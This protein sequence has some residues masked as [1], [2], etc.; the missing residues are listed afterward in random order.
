MQGEYDEIDR[1]DVAWLVTGGGLRRAREDR[2]AESERMYTDATAC[3]RL[4][5]EDRVRIA[6]QDYE[7]MMEVAA[8]DRRRAKVAL[9]ARKGG[10]DGGSVRNE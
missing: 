1:I 4:R 8:E 6:Y 9:G 7:D 10:T 5:H 3:E 2:V